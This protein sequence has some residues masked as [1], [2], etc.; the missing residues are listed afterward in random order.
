MVR[1]RA[2]A[3]KEISHADLIVAADRLR[4]RRND[5]LFFACGLASLIDLQ[6]WNKLF[7][8]L[9]SVMALYAAI[10][11]V[12][13]YL[14]AVKLK[15]RAS[16]GEQSAVDACEN[17]RS[18]SSQAPCAQERASDVGQFHIHAGGCCDPS[19]TVNEESGS[20]DFDSTS[21]GASRVAEGRPTVSSSA[22]RAMNEHELRDWVNARIA[23]YG[24]RPGLGTILAE[25]ARTF[26][27]ELHGI[28]GPLLED[29]LT[30][31]P[32]MIPVKLWASERGWYSAKKRQRWAA[33]LARNEV[34]ISLEKAGLLV[35]FY[36]NPVE[37]VL[38]PYVPPHWACKDFQTFARY[39]VPDAGAFAL[40]RKWRIENS[41]AITYLLSTRLKRYGVALG[42]SYR[43]YAPFDY[44]EVAIVY[45]HDSPAI[46]VTPLWKGETR[47][48]QLVRSVFPD[49]CR[50]Y[51]AQWLGRQHLDVYVP[52]RRV[53]F[54]YQGE[55]H[56]SPVPY[57]K[58]QEGYK[59]TKERDARKK[60]ACRQA[61][62]ALIEWK[63]D[64]PICREH[65]LKRLK[66]AGIELP[67][68]QD[69]TKLTESSKSKV[70][71]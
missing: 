22:V 16:E 12:N 67:H 42:A 14:I 68:Y 44:A 58:G 65:L 63:Y 35:R 31:E 45:P 28:S 40:C 13:L 10:A 27:R 34:G 32:L 48:A 71:T 59:R 39:I 69:L 41:V 61:G 62:V 26:D 33:L 20:K 17:M 19:T 25:K 21:P 60:E 4:A 6:N 5:S 15:R 43:Y 18:E 52:S 23:K 50:Q 49:T 54:E 36:M 38:H 51:S 46:V 66:Q 70:T 11:Q 2:E 53:G 7:F 55:Q 8:L 1:D 9:P 29:L 47:L 3:R 30:T 64:E 37:W 24:S 57:F 56:Y